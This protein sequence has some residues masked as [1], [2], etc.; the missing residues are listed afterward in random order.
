MPKITN[1][2]IRDLAKLLTTH[3]LSEIEIEENDIR[4]R[5]VRHRESVVSHVETAARAPASVPNIDA[6]A[7]SASNDTTTGE[8]ADSTNTVR[9]PMVGTLYTSPD[10]DAPPFIKAGDSVREG[11]TLFIIE[12]MKT[13]NAIAAPRAGIVKSIRAQNAHAVEYDEIL[14]VIE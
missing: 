3:D 14:A 13:M 5:V 11:Q 9:A 2:T 4:I 6:E 12:A 8:D 7:P 1:R 10:P